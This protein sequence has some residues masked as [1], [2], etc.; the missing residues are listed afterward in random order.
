MCGMASTHTDEFSFLILITITGKG[1]PDHGFLIN[2]PMLTKAT[3][4]QNQVFLMNQ[5]GLMKSR[6]LD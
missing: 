5:E 3:G 1:L 4:L 2:R 6:G